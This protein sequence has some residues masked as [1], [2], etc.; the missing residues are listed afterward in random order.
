MVRKDEMP[1][2]SAFTKRV[3]YGIR[4]IADKKDISGAQ[5]AVGL[6]RSKAYVS[7]RMNGLKG[8]TAEDL[9]RMGRI[10]GFSDAFAFLEAIREVTSG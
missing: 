8:W 2:T 3:A 1:A 5:I 7:E 9:D 10:L 4:L 6:D